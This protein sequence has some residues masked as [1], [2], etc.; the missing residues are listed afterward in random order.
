MN[1]AT[2][3]PHTSHLREVCQQ[4]P[5]STPDSERLKL[6][7]TLIH[8]ILEGLND[9]S[10]KLKVGDAL[11]AIQLR[12]KV[13]KTSEAEQIFWQMIEDI[14]KEE[15]PAP[16][17]QFTNLQRQIQAA[18]L[19]L[20]DFVKNAILP[21]KTI[22][23]AFNNTRSE[24]ARLTSRRMSKLLSGMGFTMVKTSNGCSAIIWDDDLLPA[25]PHSAPPEGPCRSGC[26]AS[27]SGEATRQPIE[28]SGDAEGL[29]SPSGVNRMVHAEAGCGA[30][31]RPED[32]GRRVPRNNRKIPS[33]RGPKGDEA[34][35]MLLSPRRSGCDPALGGRTTQQSAEHR[36]NTSRGDFI[37]GIDV[38][39]LNPPTPL[40]WETTESVPS[41][42]Y[43]QIHPG[44]PPPELSRRLAHSSPRMKTTIHPLPGGE[45]KGP[46]SP[47][48][49]EPHGSHL[50]G[51]ELK[52]RGR[53]SPRKPAMEKNKNKP[54]NPL[55]ALKH[56]F[57]AS[58]DPPRG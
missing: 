26:F 52:E 23:E 17:S 4:S 27:E 32:S 6:L 7:D 35:P 41:P 44:S 42:T 40:P 8:K 16:D 19:E 22:A 12:E 31:A 30:R 36:A 38:F 55:K 20:K 57:P 54:Q 51:E 53:S 46:S 10:C 15:Y 21:V 24:Q 13:A 5:S 18:V 49:C 58:R 3:R 50:V 37:Q 33:L 1:E 14:K 29:S 56:Q 9:N 25:P 28:A 2:D 34:I 47:S 43:P 45:G 11:K 48:Q 39:P